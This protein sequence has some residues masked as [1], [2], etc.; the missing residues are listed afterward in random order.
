LFNLFYPQQLFGSKLAQG[1][2]RVVFTDF[3][4]QWK[5]QTRL[6]SRLLKRL[7]A[8][9][10]NPAGRPAGEATVPAVAR[11][12]KRVVRQQAFAGQ[13]LQF[14]SE[15]RRTRS[16][17]RGGDAAD[18]ASQPCQSRDIEK[19]KSPSA[20]CPTPG[21]G[22][23]RD[24]SCTRRC[25]ASRPRPRSA[26]RGSA[27]MED[28]LQACRRRLRCSRTHRPP[29]TEQRCLVGQDSDCK[30]VGSA[31]LDGAVGPDGNIDG[32]AG[33]AVVQKV[34]SATLLKRVEAASSSPSSCFR[35]SKSSRS[36]TCD[37]SRTT[38]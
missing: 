15:G 36:P 11:T 33:G 32:C 2:G 8:A 25:S 9:N 26:Q 31:R 38:R 37:Y 6:Q 27:C 13:L 22:S 23:R 20:H 24:V 17:A 35:F 12:F 21:S 30:F 10:K 29:E 34:A 28:N 4:K 19:Q 3:E 7:S 16:L 14:E 5:S 18:P 1:L